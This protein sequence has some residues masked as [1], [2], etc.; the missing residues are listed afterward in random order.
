[1]LASPPANTGGSFCDANIVR[2]AR[3]GSLNEPVFDNKIYRDR[4]LNK[5]LRNLCMAFKTYV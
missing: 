1:M 4:D 5:Q 3:Y 2:C